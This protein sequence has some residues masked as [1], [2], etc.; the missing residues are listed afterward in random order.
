MPRPPWTASPSAWRRARSWRSSAPPAAGRRRR[1]GSW[2][3]SRRPMPAS[4]RSA[5]R[6]WRDPDGPCRRSH[7]ASAWSSRTTPCFPTCRSR[8]TWRS[9]SPTF[10]AP[11]GRAASRGRSSW[12]AWSAST[13]ALSA[14]ALGRP[15]AARR[16]RP[17][18]RAGAR[19]HPARRAVLESRR[20]SP[21]GDARGDRQDPP[22]HRDHGHLRDPRPAGGVRAGGSRRRPER[23]PAR[24]GRPVVRALPPARQPVRRRVRGRRGL[25]AVDGDRGRHRLGA[26]HPAAPARAGARAGGRHHDP[27][28]R[29]RLH[30]APGRR[31]RR[32]GRG[33]STETSTSTGSA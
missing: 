13:A 19:A 3:A 21:R 4:S 1:S 9:G 2:R 12:S 25:P 7:G 30:P 22:R 8:P 20:R 17:R 28:R 24:A 14:R 31:R 15:A 18:A 11:R 26:G 32:G 23:G 5:A 33:S 27:P 16:A 10:R 29:H 6:Q